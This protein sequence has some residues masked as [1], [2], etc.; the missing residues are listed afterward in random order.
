MLCHTLRVVVLLA[1]VSGTGCIGAAV[2]D[3]LGRKSALTLA[4]RD[5]TK[6]VRWG[7]IEAAADYV[8]PELREQFLELEAQF[9]GIRMT[10]FDIGKIKYGENMESATVRVTYRAYSM[11]TFI[12]KEIKE[13][14]AW[15]R[16][17]RSNR[18]WVKPELQGILDAMSDL[19][20]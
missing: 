6:F 17:G 4:Q 10:E 8:H 11:R 13:T 1:L 15:E 19:R 9:D 14:Q 16:E 2:T 12:E 20:G 3:P 5:Y 7:D 18:W